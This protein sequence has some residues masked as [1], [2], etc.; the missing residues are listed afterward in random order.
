[1]PERCRQVRLVRRSPQGQGEPTGSD[2]CS[3]SILPASKGSANVNL[4]TRKLQGLTIISEGRGAIG[5]VT[6]FPTD[7]PARALGRNVCFTT[8]RRENGNK[9]TSIGRGGNRKEG[10]GE[11]LPLLALRLRDLETVPLE[12]ARHERG[13]RHL[14]PRHKRDPRPAEIRERRGGG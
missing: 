6:Y 9:S 10:R 7:R 3:S 14:R 5:N 8:G 13:E 11:R 2:A 4:L 1:M 12:P